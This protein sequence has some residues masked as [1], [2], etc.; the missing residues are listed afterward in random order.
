M[1]RSVVVLTLLAFVV[2]LAGAAVAQQTEQDILKKYLSKTEK[3]HVQHQGWLSVNFTMNR[4]NRHNDYNDFANYASTQMTGSSFSWLNMSKSFGGE[5][6]VSVNRRFGFALGGEYWL[7]MGETI[8]GSFEYQPISTAVSNPSS[9]IKTYGGFASIIYYVT[10]PPTPQ[11]GLKH[12]AVRTRV[13]VGYYQTKWDLWPEY[14]NLNL[15]TALPE[16]S[17]LTYTGSAP[18]FSFT[19]GGD[20]PLGASGF[21]IGTEFGYQYLNFKNV[22]WYNDQDQE[23]VVTTAGT[24]ASRVDLTFSGVIGRVELKKF[25]K[26]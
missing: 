15:S 25:F 11:E 22:S 2:S 17:N 23:V 12:L 4:I 14:Q 13:T 24:A 26:W 9:E 20:Y 3:K 21:S 19:L 5:F 6:G 7:K 16:Q 10:N 18:A 1:R 8:T